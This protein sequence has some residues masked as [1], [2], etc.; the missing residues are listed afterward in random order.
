MVRLVDTN[1]DEREALIRSSPLQAS[2]AFG[3][4][5]S[6]SHSRVA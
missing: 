1:G 2:I 4:D 6:T 5:T 3:V